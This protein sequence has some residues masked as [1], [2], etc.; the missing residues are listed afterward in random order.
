M[1]MNWIRR[2]AGMPRP[3]SSS[4]LESGP[5]VL[6]VQDRT[7]PSG[8]DLH[9]DDFRPLSVSGHVAHLSLS[10]PTE[11]QVAE[12]IA[13]KPLRQHRRHGAAIRAVR[14]QS[15]V[16]EVP[17]RSAPPLHPGQCL[18]RGARSQNA[19]RGPGR[20]DKPAPTTWQ[21]ALGS[22]PALGD[23]ELDQRFLGSNHIRPRPQVCRT[24]YG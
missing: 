5:T 7:S 20:C 6:L 2:A 23:G 3:H 15:G 10:E 13:R 1:S 8:A 11:H 24:K 22:V 17:R 4:P 16:R 18:A 14:Q 9:P 21:P 12:L 19:T